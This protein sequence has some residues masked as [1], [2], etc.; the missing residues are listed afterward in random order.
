MKAQSHGR[1]EGRARLHRGEGRLHRFPRRNLHVGVRRG[2]RHRA[3]SAPSSRSW[4]GTT[5]NG[6]IR[7]RCWRWSGSS[8]G[9]EVSAPDRAAG[10]RQARVHP[11]RSQRAAGRRRQ[12]HGRHA[13]PRFAPRHRARAEGRR[14]GD[15]DLAPRTPDRG[16]AEARG[17]AR[18]DREAVGRDARSPG[19]AGAELGG[20]RVHGRSRAKW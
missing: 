1:H 20:R 13:H 12:H 14:R 19:A 3:R 4:R 8:R 18:A 11:R 5:T 6:A 10:R 16:Q 2:S 17:L 9:N 7:A 15:G